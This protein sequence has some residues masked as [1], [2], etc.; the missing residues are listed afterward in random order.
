M[1]EELCGYLTATDPNNKF[2]VTFF[3]RK[4]QQT[5]LT[6][7]G[8][9]QYFECFN[10]AFQKLVSMQIMDLNIA[11]LAMYKTS[12]QAIKDYN[13][14]NPTTKITEPKNLTELTGLKKT[15]DEKGGTLYYTSKHIAIAERL[16]VIRTDLLPISDCKV[17]EQFSASAREKICVVGMQAGL[18]AWKS[19]FFLGLG[20]ILMAWGMA[21]K[22]KLIKIKIDKNIQAP[23]QVGQRYTNYTLRNYLKWI[24]KEDKDQD[25][26]KE[27]QN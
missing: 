6:K 2:P 23:S 17:Y 5:L 4:N 22:E 27:Y 16:L 7:I 25:W 9:A 24:E 26:E 13:V 14:A 12:V 21:R 11:M 10:P 3:D 1:T 19:L 20:C 8:M 18:N 15:I